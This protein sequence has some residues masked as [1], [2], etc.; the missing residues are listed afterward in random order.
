ML[1]RAIFGAIYV[2][3]IVGGIVGGQVSLLILTLALSALAIC[4]FLTMTSPP[5]ADNAASWPVACALDCIGGSLICITAWTGTFFL[6]AAVTYLLYL[7]VRLCLQL[8]LKGDNA[9]RSLSLSFMSQL[10]IALPVA[11]MSVVYRI[12]PHLLLLLFALVWVNDTFAYLTGCT[13]GRHRLFER[14]SPKKS[15]E[16]FWGGLVFTVACALAAGLLMRGSFG[17]LSPIGVA[18]LGLVVSIAATLGDLVESLIKRTVGV[19]DSGHLIPGHGGILDRIDSIL[20]VV[21]ISLIYL[22][23]TYIHAV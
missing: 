2:A 12:S 22:F 23:I 1:K 8:W 18:I 13:F 4:E 19:K 3:A 5:Q 9:L 14:I 11:M 17:A 16:G 15:W 10:Y 20:L 6:P 7:C 21:P